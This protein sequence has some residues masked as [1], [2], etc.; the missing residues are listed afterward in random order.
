MD[1]GVGSLPYSLS[2]SEGI[3]QY[4]Y[5][6]PFLTTVTRADDRFWSVDGI[7][8]SKYT[9]VPASSTF[10]NREDKETK[11]IQ[12]GGRLLA[13]ETITELWKLSATLAAKHYADG[14]QFD[15]TAKDKG[16]DIV[17]WTPT[18]TL[19]DYGNQNFLALIYV[20][21]ADGDCLIFEKKFVMALHMSHCDG[22]QTDFVCEI[23]I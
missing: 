4:L 16:N 8:F 2:D 15:L 3:L 5:N 13:M 22:H 14:Y 11:C 7:S 6:I 17:Y 1:V 18:D 20:D 23:P 10:N 9:T 19:L 12:Y 21:H